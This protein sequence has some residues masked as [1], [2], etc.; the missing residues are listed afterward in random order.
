VTL[1]RWAEQWLEHL[2]EQGGA[3]SSIVTHRSV[4]RAHVLP[5][6]GRRGWWISPADIDELIA[7]VRARPS[8]QNPK[9][10]ANAVAP[11]V[12]RTLRA[13]ADRLW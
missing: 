1:D 2:R 6:L 9:A 10:K 7:G 13:H 5:V 4:L 3:E 12:L 11:N 8:K